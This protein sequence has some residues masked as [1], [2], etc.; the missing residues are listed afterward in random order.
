MERV[1]ANQDRSEELRK[2]YVYKQHIHIA[3]HKPNTRIMREETADYDVAPS[4]EGT[5]KHL[6]SL[7]GRYWKKDKYVEIEGGPLLEAP[8]TDADLIRNLRDYQ[9]ALD[10]AKTDADLIH[11]LRSYLLEDDS[12]DGV[13]RSL[14]PLTDEQQKNYTFTL[15]AEETDEGRKVYH[16]AFAPKETPNDKANSTNGDLSWTGE[17]FIDAQEFQPVRVFTKMT[18]HVPFLVRMLWFDL[19]GLGFNVVYQRQPDG[20][21][22]PWIF[23]TE[24]HMHTGAVIYFNRDVSISVEN[25]G[26]EHKRAESK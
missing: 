1:A 20:V 19:P 14:F 4:P 18:G 16:I 12:K 25:S 22:F 21:W 26:F 6:N 11:Y 7:I 23:G 17:A 2:E 9:P 8:R 3:T 24:F 13:A 15:I 5:V 10:T